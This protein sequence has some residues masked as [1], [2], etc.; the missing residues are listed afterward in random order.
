M[1]KVHMGGDWYLCTGRIGMCGQHSV[2][3]AHADE[4]STAAQ[5]SA[6]IGAAKPAFVGQSVLWQIVAR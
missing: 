1:Y 4:Y 3:E 2:R 5:A 6:A